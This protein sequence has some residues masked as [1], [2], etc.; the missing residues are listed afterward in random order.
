[1]TSRIRNTLAAVALAASALAPAASQAA[2]VRLSSWAYGN[3]W[4][5]QVKVGTPAHTGAA[6]GFKGSVDFDAGEE[7]QGW[8]DVADPDFITYCIEITESFHGFPSALM[9]GY[10]VRSAAAYGWSAARAE[11]IGRLMSHV[12]ADPTRV[13][14]KDES[15]A[16]QLALWNLVYDTDADLSLL[17]GDFRETGSSTFETYADALLAASANAA[18]RYEVH[19]LSKAGSQDFL[20]LRQV[21]EPA[22]LALCLAALGGVGLSRRRRRADAGAAAAPR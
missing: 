17:A 12:A 9:A 4:N 5:N 19:V 15:T 7:A 10:E 21:P 14:H 1:M 16:L 22:T 3:S 2:V 8:V 13:D 20:L 11:R 6:G 18:N